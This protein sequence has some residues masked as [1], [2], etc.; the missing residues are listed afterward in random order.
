[1]PARRHGR[2][3]CAHGRWASGALREDHPDFTSYS[4]T[5]DGNGNHTRKTQA[6]GS[7][8]YGIDAQNK[9]LWTNTTNVAPTSG[10]AAPYRLYTYNAN[11]EPTQIEHRD[12]VGGLVV[13][14]VL[15]WDGMG[16]PR[17]VLTGST[18]V[19]EARYDGGGNRVE[20][21]T[22]AGTRT[23]SYGAGL[24]YEADSLVG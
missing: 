7:A 4:Y 6:A 17:Q 16:K 13:T 18:S 5:P 14:E 15:K 24:M 21:T 9:L 20:S 12:T 19:Y 10:Q 3:R 2:Q 23:Y 8:F 1:M 22:S 11:G